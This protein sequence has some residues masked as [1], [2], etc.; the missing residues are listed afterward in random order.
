MSYKYPSL[1]TTLPVTG[2]YARLDAGA[3]ATDQFTADGT[4]NG[5]LTNGATR[6]NVGG[7]AYSLDGAND[8]IA[9]GNW[10]VTGDT[11]RTVAAWV[12]V[13]SSASGSRYLFTMGGVAGNQYFAMRL[14]ATGASGQI[15]LFCSSNDWQV[16]SNVVPK[17]Q[18][19]HIAVT[20]SGGGTSTTAVKFYVNGILQTTTFAGGSPATLS[21]T[22]TTCEIGRVQGVAN[23]LGYMDDF[24][25]WKAD[26]AAQEIG[27]LAAERGAIYAELP[28]SQRRRISQS[29]V[30]SMF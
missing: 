4:Q 21:T 30:R 3:A 5:T 1:R 2:Y 11:A 9:C 29:S 24:L 8:Y 18:W 19:A 13:T 10:G 14:D 25:V 28:T 23:Y 22:N 7:L 17:N 12:Y 15:Y 26:L 16:A 6:A 27:Y 20:Y